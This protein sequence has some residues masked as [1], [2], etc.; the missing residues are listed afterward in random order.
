MSWVFWVR[1]ALNLAVAIGL[2]YVA[3]VLS[4]Q[5]VVNR[6]I[7][8]LRLF[9]LGAG[10]HAASL[11]LLTAISAIGG[12]PPFYVWSMVNAFEIIPAI[13]LAFHVA[14]FIE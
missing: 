12:S 6:T 1:G 11:A 2:L 5:K 7:Y 4:K 8:Y 14:G 3:W 10:L 9:V 13:A